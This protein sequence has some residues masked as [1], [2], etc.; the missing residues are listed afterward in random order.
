M[1]SCSR[2]TRSVVLCAATLLAGC[3]AS[4]GLEPLELGRSEQSVIGGEMDRETSGVVALAL[5]LGRS[6]AGYCS[7]TL[8]APNLV[9]TAR[10]CVALTDDGATEGVVDCDETRFTRPLPA[11]RILATSAAERPT[12]ANDASYVRASQVR[13]LGESEQICGHD[14]ALII[15]DGSGMPS[16]VRPITPR[17]EI[18]PEPTESF[19]VVGYGLTDPDD[20]SSDG[21]R[22]RVDGSVVLCAGGG[23]DSSG[24]IR[25]SEW[26]SRNA[27]VCS[28]DSGG[29]ALDSEGRVFGVASRG[30]LDCEVAVYGDVASW[31]SFIAD[32][33][34]EAASL[35]RYDAPE[36]AK[37]VS[38][39]A[40]V[41]PDASSSASSACNTG[42]VGVA[43]AR[44]GAWLLLGCAL[45]LAR[46]TRRDGGA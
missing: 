10:H 19:S 32:T 28:G 16:S 12:S 30:D 21:T 14:I 11:R 2:R 44:A 29:P 3:G 33:A 41:D 27:P 20:P 17:L 4:D 34:I 45:L 39:R 1:G 22:Q 38:S 24:S 46:R 26:A 8:I 5:D 7:G 43:P 23:C 42:P 36:W 18:S 15:L 37:R 25:D 40:Q 35:G 31:S 13:V 9:L 6:V